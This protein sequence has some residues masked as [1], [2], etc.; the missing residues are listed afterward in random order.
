MHGS[1]WYVL[2]ALLALLVAAG[3][4][5]TYPTRAS[6]EAL[7]ASVNRSAGELFIIG[8]VASVG[9]GGVELW[10]ILGA[11][12]IFI[13]LASVFTVVR[14]TRATEEDG[15][16]EL[17]GSAA[18]GRAAPLVAVLV[19]TAAGS[20]LAGAIVTSGF[21]GT[22]AGVLGSTLA[23]AQ[24]TMTGLLGASL[25]AV[26]GQLMR[27]ARGATGVAIAVVAACF[28]LRGAG[29]VIGGDALWL[30]PF[31]WIAAVRPFAA[32]DAAMLLPALA[33][34]ALL[35]AVAVRVAANRD[36]GA[37]MVAERTGPARAGRWLRGPVSL[38]LRTTRGT[39]LG[40]GVG[41]LVVGV[42]IGGVATT[43]DTQVELA[44]GSGAGS[45]SGL[46][47]VALYLAPLF[48][49]V[50]GLQVVLRLR[51][52]VA[53]GRAEAVLSRPVGRDRWLLA[54]VAAAV[55]GAATVLL[56]FGLGIATASLGT[57]PERFAPTAVAGVL[58]SPAPWVFITLGALLL[59]VIPR[60]AAAVSY[61]VVGAFQALEFAVEFRLLPADALL[62]SP[63]AVVPQAP[64]GAAHV[65]QTI[66]LVLVAAA[67]GLLAAIAVRHRDLR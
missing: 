35:A 27:T 9:P 3:I 18:I 64:D 6:R 2:T 10:R 52:E 23:G 53:S 62:A 32:D 26:T 4:A 33:L 51:G 56:A 12:T 15:T 54:H 1:A 17:S 29:D 5:S 24:I 14:N 65:W 20:L 30:S 36:L 63:F 37:G 13:S 67:L 40:W 22:G 45:G 34:A 55:L 11:A 57:F 47:D 42:L 49:T 41:A 44:L 43:V 66:V 61:T 38:A 60:A 25:A 8:P 58:R 28:L 46:V 59:A 50:L 48:A 19:V 16:S 39:I 7:A 21:I 31:G